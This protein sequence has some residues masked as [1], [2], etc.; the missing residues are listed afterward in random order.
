MAARKQEKFDVLCRYVPC[1]LA[2][3]ISDTAEQLELLDEGETAFDQLLVVD[4][5]LEELRHAIG[6]RDLWCADYNH[7]DGWWYH[8]PIYDD[9]DMCSDQDC[10]CHTARQLGCGGMVSNQITK[11]IATELQQLDDCLRVVAA[12]KARLIAV[13]DNALVLLGARKDLTLNQVLA[14]RCETLN[15]LYSAH[16]ES[17]APCTRSGRTLLATNVLTS[18]HT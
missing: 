5:L 9:E 3:I 1:D 13:I 18:L 16:M 12:E 8:S 4:D 6:E 17:R 15:L 2:R 10:A 11:S 7:E 14:A